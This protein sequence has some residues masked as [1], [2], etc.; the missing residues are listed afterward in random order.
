MSLSR[1][2]SVAFSAFRAGSLRSLL[3]RPSGRSFS[4]I[5]LVCVFASG[6]RAFP[7][8]A[9]WAVR[10]GVGVRVRR[11]PLGW[12]VSVPVVRSSSRLP[13]S[14]RVVAWRGGLRGFVAAL[15]HSGLGV[16]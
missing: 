9:R 7:F 12:Q 15:G 4:G 10:L 8:A 11:H 14:G 5:V 2:R 16:S 13:V 1:C 3:L 6:P